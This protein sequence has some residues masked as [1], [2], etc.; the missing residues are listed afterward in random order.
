MQTVDDALRSAARYLADNGVESARVDAELI[1]ARVLEIDRARLVAR[2]T[3]MLA[4]DQQQQFNRWIARRGEKREPVAYI[5]GSVEFYG[6]ELFVSPSVLI[7]RPETEVLVERALAIVGD[8]EAAVA[9]IGTGSGAIAIAIAANSKARVVATD[10]SPRVLA[11]AEQNSVDTQGKRG[12]I[13]FR[14]GDLFE[15]L[16]AERFDLICSNPPYVSVDEFD[17][18]APELKHEPKVALVCGDGLFVIRRLAVGVRQ[19][20]NAGG[21]LL[22]E[23]GAGQAA[24]AQELFYAAGFTGVVFHK[25]LA[26]IDRVLEAW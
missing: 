8:R 16:H 24:E 5:T 9:D 2:G 21:R 3:A 12:T 11:V 18:L 25:D 13:E 7:P 22:L 6:I 15:P 19:H 10:I 4:D 17:G 26:G 20:L 14:E 1:M 23:I